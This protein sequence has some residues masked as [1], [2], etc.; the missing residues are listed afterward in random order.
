MRSGKAAR[1]ESGFTYIGVLLLV[2]VVGLWLAATGTVWHLEVQRDKEREL[3][4]IGNQFRDA[5]DRYAASTVGSARR[6]PLRLEDLVLD[7]RFAAKRRH[8]RRIYR[9][10]MTGREDWGVIRTGDGQIIGVHSLSTEVPVKRAN[11]AI[12]DLAFTSKA[13]YGQW[14]FMART[15]RSGLLSLSAAPPKGGQGSVVGA[16]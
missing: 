8:L 14:V 11:F 10:P 16:E 2:T 3:L 12:R 5:L 4:Y 7:E 6:F 9:D 15:A 1:R 13:N